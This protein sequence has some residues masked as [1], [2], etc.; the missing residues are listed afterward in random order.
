MR[1]YEILKEEAKPK[2]ISS[3]KYAWVPNT[4]FENFFMGGPPRYEFEYKGEKY[5]AQDIVDAAKKHGSLYRAGAGGKKSDPIR[6]VIKTLQALLSKAGLKP[7][8]I[9]GFYGKKTAQAVVRIQ[10]LLRVTVDGDVGPQTAGNLLKNRTILISNSLADKGKIEKIK[11]G[12]P[13]PSGIYK[14]L[15]AKHAKAVADIDGLMY[16]AAYGFFMDT[17]FERLDTSKSILDSISKQGGMLDPKQYDAMEWTIRWLESDEPFAAKDVVKR[18]Q[19]FNKSSEFKKTDIFKKY[20]EIW[21]KQNAV[22]WYDVPEEIRQDFDRIP[23]YI[24][25]GRISLAKDIIQNDIVPWWMTKHASKVTDKDLPLSTKAVAGPAITTKNR[26]V[27]AGDKE[28][29]QDVDAMQAKIG[30]IKNSMKRLRTK[31]PASL[32]KLEQQ[33]IQAQRNGDYEKAFGFFDTWMKQYENWLSN[34]DGA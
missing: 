3:N 32:E 31:L 10:R 16:P 21:N 27:V 5:E 28:L 25:K 22:G 6:K 8:P 29:M 11:D 17:F 19:A 23:D 12:K 18:V 1:L 13:V 20:E 14:A 15:Q 34:Q 33:A 9:D 2:K 4:D 30:N 26:E 24:D 7:G